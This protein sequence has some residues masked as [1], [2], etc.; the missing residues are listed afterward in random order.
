[1]P[2]QSAVLAFWTRLVETASAERDRWLLWLPVAV[3]AGIALYYALP[4]EP[5]LWPAGLVFAGAV[6]AAW[7]L[8]RWTAFVLLAVAIAAGAAGFAAAKLRTLVVEAPILARELGLALVEGRVLAAE[9]GEAGGRIVIAQPRI[10]RLAPERTPER[11]RIRL[12]RSDSLPPVGARVRLRAML[13]PPTPPA[14]P[15]AYDF[16]RQAFFERIGAVGY[17]LGR[18]SVIES[19]PADGGVLAAAR[20][21]VATLR[22]T[23]H[24]RVMAALPQAD[25]ADA[26]GAMT[27]ALLHGEQSAIPR[28]AMDDMRDAGLAHLLAIS[29]FNVALV[30]GALFVSLRL[31]FAA[32]GSLA[33]YWPT[34]K[35]AAALTIIGI[36]A[37]TL[38]TGAS[39]PTLRSF[40]M[41]AVVLIAVMLDR[42]AIS[43]RLVM[44][45]GL[46][47]LLFMPESL[48][49]ASFQMSFAAVIALIAAYESSR[50]WTRRQ[51]AEGGKLR[52]VALYAGGLVATSLIAGLAT[53][54]FA[55]F[56][57][58]RLA[59]YQL[60]ANL[61]A[62]PITAVW[63]TPWSLLAYLLMPFGWES[64]ALVPMSW[65][66]E[67]IIAVAREV[68]SWPDAVI[69][70][71]SLP[72]AGLALV[73]LGG[74]WL[75]LWRARWRYAGLPAIAAGLATMLSFTPPDVIVAPETGLFAAR[76]ANGD[77]QFAATSPSGQAFL[78]DVWRRRS[79]G[80]LETSAEVPS[81]RCD[82][83]GCLY[84][85]AGR[86]VALLRD[87]AALAEDCA[88]ADVVVSWGA[89]WPARCKGP[90]LLLDRRALAAGGTHAI[91]LEPHGIT[92]A[93]VRAERGERP[94][95]K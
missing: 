95:S 44:A 46:A 49:G 36:F 62:V 67:A 1:M 84:R 68:A 79:V 65:G 10:A 39:L 18:A 22:Q 53:A 90:R 94:W 61:V 32:M 2:F 8:R 3:A 86:S 57:F 30:A 91:W 5:T 59:V 41:T 11:V 58:N 75:C 34:K 6:L 83:L 48:L 56:H 43:L 31:L 15:G 87:E 19:A 74:L 21:Y 29:G 26:V 40:L 12:S 7:L 85:A 89:L 17:A 82:A 76:G 20:L 47:L 50:S 60:A 45:A 81:L 37:Y 9:P 64:V 55:A 88:A 77:L 35:W 93:N 72:Q 14:M 42:T 28:R 13:L 51:R 4:F 16:G 27:A 78:R 25:R 70:L 73:T 54:P 71:P 52:R 92:I 69:A 23:I 63:I 33:L 66:V 24:A 38:I 80:L